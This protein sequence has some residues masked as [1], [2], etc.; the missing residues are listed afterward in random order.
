[1]DSQ[2]PEYKMVFE[3]SEGSWL[4]SLKRDWEGQ[5]ERRCAPQRAVG[6]TVLS[7]TRAL[8]KRAP[9]I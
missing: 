3:E 9:Y 8:K 4:E 5:D 6:R 7:G 1:M 2:T